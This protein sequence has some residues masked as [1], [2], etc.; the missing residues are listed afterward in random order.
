MEVSIIIPAYKQEEYVADAVESALQQTVACEVIVINDGSPDNTRK[1]IDKYPVQIIDQVNKGLASAR[2][3]GI[4]NATGKYILP[5]DADDILY[6]T[7]VEKMLGVFK[8]TDADV[9][10]P[11]MK[12]F[13]NSDETVIIM[14]EPQIEDFRIAN[15]IPYASMIKRESLLE[16][17]GYSPKMDTLGGFEDYHLWFDLLF[18]GKKIVGIQEPLLLYR[19]K[20]DSMY[21]R[22]EKNRPKLMEQIFKDF[23]KLL[24]KDL[25]KRKEENRTADWL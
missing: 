1:I 19:T 22:A 20:K 12:C 15:R 8:E 23:P 7:C 3:T 16:C 9:V 18:R 13:G 4:M 17:G 10:A 11:S 21:K 24:P 6:D 2:N 14:Q 5:L 25:A